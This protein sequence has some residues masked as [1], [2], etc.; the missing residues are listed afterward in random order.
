MGADPAGLGLGVGTEAVETDDSAEG[1][2]DCV[3][4]V[5]FMR[6]AANRT[7]VGTRLSRMAPGVDEVTGSV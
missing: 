1:V 6:S 2:D 5:F 3:T 4:G 7:L